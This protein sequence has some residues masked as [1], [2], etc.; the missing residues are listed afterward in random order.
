MD[1]SQI[2][3]EILTEDA[4]NDIATSVM[5]ENP[6]KAGDVNEV[7]TATASED[8][9]E[10]DVKATENLD[11]ADADADA[12]AN[13][14]ADADDPDEVSIDEL[15]NGKREEEEEDIPG[16]S[17]KA[18]KKIDARI[19]KAIKEKKAALKRVEEVEA[20]NETLKTQ[21]APKERP[22]PPLEDDFATK[23]EYQKAMIEWKDADDDFKAAEGKKG[24]QKKAMD[25]KYAR[26]EE[27]YK[28][29]VERVKKTH[30]D[31]DEVVKGTDYDRFSLAISL[32]EVGGELDYYLSRNPKKFDEIKGMDDLSAVLALGSIA[33]QVKRAMNTKRTT[34]APK[35]YKAVKGMDVRDEDVTETSSLN[36]VIQDEL[37][38][39]KG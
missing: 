12:D 30:P 16:V 13:A 33:G 39:Y 11:D 24:I 27:L 6:Q 2:G 29:S 31:F 26:A 36:K 9:G 32:T 18:Q 28:E 23:E 8:E 7:D 5:E 17:P 22:T 25:E 19:G 21:L 34:K 37:G 1:E 20:E 35:P 14:N 15:I 4:I 3:E 10:G 38:V